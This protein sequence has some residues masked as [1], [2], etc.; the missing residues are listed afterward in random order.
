MSVSINRNPARAPGRDVKWIDGLRGIAALLIVTGHTMLCFDAQNVFPSVG[1]DGP[2]RLFQRPYLR[3]LAGQGPAWVALFFILSGYVNALKP[4]RLTEE[5]NVDGAL[6]GI[7]ISS[8]RR[9]FRLVLPASV[10]TIASWLLTQLHFFELARNSDAGWYRD[11][12]AL[13]SPNLG[14]AIYDLIYNLISTWT[15]ADNEY[16]KPQWTL[17]HLL[18]GSF[19]TYLFLV[20]TVHVANRHRLWVAGAVYSVYYLRNDRTLKRCPF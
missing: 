11:N 10:V 2:L 8:F 6:G 17:V 13:P 7:A 20:A 9:S 4:V 15:H 16:E 19:Y 14:R 18:K 12:S 3:L 5:G 1:Q